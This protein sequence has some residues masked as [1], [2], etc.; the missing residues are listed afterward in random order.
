MTRYTLTGT[1]IRKI[2]QY[3]LY[4]GEGTVRFRKIGKVKEKVYLIKIHKNGNKQY[5][6]DIKNKTFIPAL[7]KID[8][9][10]QDRISRLLNSQRK[11]EIVSVYQMGWDRIIVFKFRDEGKLIIELFSGGNI[12]YIDS[13]NTIIEA[14]REFETKKRVIKRGAKY[15]FPT[16]GYREKLENSER[17]S[18]QELFKLLPFDPMLIEETFSED[19]EYMTTE[20]LRRIE[21]IEKRIEESF[22][23]EKFYLYEYRDKYYIQPYKMKIGELLGE[24][25]LEELALKIIRDTLYSNNKLIRIQ[26]EIDKLDQKIIDLENKKAKM[27]QVVEELYTLTNTLSTLLYMINQGKMVDN[28]EDGDMRI[29][30]INRREKTVDIEYKG[31]KIKLRYD[32][33]L[34]ASISELYDYIKKLDEAII[35]LKSKREALRQSAERE[36]SNISSIK[37]KKTMKKQ[38]F[39]KFIWSISRNGLLIIAGKDATTNEILVKKY[40]DKNDLVFHAEI[41]GSPFTILK[42]GLFSS[43]DDIKD[44]AIIT[45]SY[46]N[47]WKH[48]ITYVPV[49]YFT[50]DQI[51]KQAPSGQYLSK[52]SFMIYGDKRYVKDIEIAL[53]ISI[54]ELNDEKRIFIGSREAV[55]ANCEKIMFMIYPGGKNSRGEAAKNIVSSLINKGYLDEECRETMYND[56]VNRLPNGK[57]LVKKFI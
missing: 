8:E 54:Y 46:S 6:I 23:D 57:I 48:S 31:E 20:V 41:R 45:A 2:L 55:E 12:L 19:R 5:I 44:A 36:I 25:K 32:K 35:N 51:S 22:G 53:Y 39:E 18:K 10:S 42:N 56:L 21:N 11:N 30:T 24:Y 15:T 3:T 33:N 28:Y 37:Q 16:E 17:I 13:N 4:S 50:K 34:Y 29:L 40:L 26:H 1:S 52:G 9:I 27:K 47:A 38:W 49:Y 43:E 7:I 14:L